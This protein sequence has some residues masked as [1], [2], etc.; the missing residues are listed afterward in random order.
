MLELFYTGIII[1]VLV[2]CPMGPMGMLCIQRTLS[3]GKLSGF[4]SG[5]GAAFSDIL[6]AALTC[7]FVGLVDNFIQANQRPFQIF[8]SVVILLFGYYIFRNNPAASPNTA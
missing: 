4:I 3:K 2:S 6:Y 8:G 5:L 1:G 7:F